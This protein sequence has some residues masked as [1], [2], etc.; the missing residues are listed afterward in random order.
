MSIP[1]GDDTKSFASESNYSI[2]GSCTDECHYLYYRVKQEGDVFC[3]QLSRHHLSPEE[4][5]VATV[6]NMNFRS[7]M[8]LVQNI[9]QGA[10]AKASYFKGHLDAANQELLGPPCPTIFYDH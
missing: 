10:S 3:V 8:C 9:S 5:R 2:Q 7:M 6:P 1:H 4:K